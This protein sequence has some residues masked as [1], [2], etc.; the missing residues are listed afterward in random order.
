METTKSGLLANFGDYLRK[1]GWGVYAAFASE[2]LILSLLSPYFLTAKN[3]FNVMKAITFT[4]VTSVGMTML[5]ISGGLDLSVGSM[6]GLGGMVPAALMMRL[7]VHPAL[8]V[9]VGLLIGAFSGFTIS[10]IVTHL[11]INSFIVTLGMLSIL[12]GFAY[13][14]SKGSNIFIR[15]KAI[16]FLGQGYLGSVPF[17]VIVMLF[18]VVIGAFFLRYTVLG[19][20]IYAVGGNERA[21]RLAG[22]Q[23]NKVRLFVF[24]TTS[25]LASFAG[26]I[27][28]GFL[29]SAEMTAGTGLELDVI[30]A[31]IIGGAS[32]NGGKGTVVGS[33]IGAAIMGVLRNG[34]ILLGLRY[35]AQIISIGVVII[36]AVVMDSLRSAKK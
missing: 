29:G 34:F 31:V 32:L 5:I 35:E 9:F 16:L 13:L 18:F 14:I 27:A 15:S 12:R 7:G 28:S 1:S 6:I 36:L 25:I 20:Q 17:P 26:I 3:L 10:M 2:C 30:A 23:V 8:A 24:I 19:R 21:A 4:G 33:L 22:V 11:K